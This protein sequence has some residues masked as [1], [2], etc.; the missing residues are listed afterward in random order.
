MNFEEFKEFMVNNQDKTNKLI[1][2]IRE[3]G[4]EIK[5]KN[6]ERKNKIN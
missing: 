2:S 4:S 3:F 1:Q 5:E 6:S